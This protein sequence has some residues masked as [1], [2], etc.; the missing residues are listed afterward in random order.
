MLTARDERGWVVIS[1]E[2]P[3]GTVATTK[4]FIRARFYRPPTSDANS[5]HY[6]RHVHWSMGPTLPMRMTRIVEKNTHLNSD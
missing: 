2:P 6:C 3:L 4:C 5:C 1:W